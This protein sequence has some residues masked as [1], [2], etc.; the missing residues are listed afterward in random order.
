MSPHAVARRRAAL[1]SALL[2][3]LL[4]L[5]TGAHADQVTLNVYTAL[6][7][8]ETDR[9][10]A[11]FNE[12]HPG[13][14]IAWERGAT[15]VITDRLLAEKDAPKADVVWGLAATSMLLLQR[16]GVLQAYAP[17]GLARLDARF[18]DAADPP[19]WVGM[20]AWVGALCVNPVETAGRKLS[21]PASWHDLSRSEYE[22]HLAMP[23]PR[24]SGT[25]FLTVVG[26]LQMLGEA[27]GWAYMDNLHRN[28]VRY[29]L[30][31]SEPCTLAARGEV[32]I[33]L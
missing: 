32:A 27:G 15:G 19:A 33:G 2:A 25:G 21:P 18:R 1:L 10:A 23:D 4:G 8:E 31:G 22:G 30:S 3:G 16:E 28:V 29:T 12:A 5:A 11:R 6:E 24:V 9:Y 14:R 20:D 13:I 26:W 17:A 7:P